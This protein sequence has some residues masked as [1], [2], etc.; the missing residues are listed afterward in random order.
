M[1]SIEYMGKLDNFLAKWGEWGAIGVR[2]FGSATVLTV[3]RAEAVPSASASNDPSKLAR[4][5]FRDGG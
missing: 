2:D 3:K 1:H 4:S 5:F